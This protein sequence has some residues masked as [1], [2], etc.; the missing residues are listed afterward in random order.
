M[1][2]EPQQKSG[3]ETDIEK[4]SREIDRRQRKTEVK[5]EIWLRRAWMKDMEREAAF[6]CRKERG[7]ERDL[8]VEK[9]A[10]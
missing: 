8:A 10:D 7:M 4:S 3:R 1:E 9:K 6:N 2:G 5:K